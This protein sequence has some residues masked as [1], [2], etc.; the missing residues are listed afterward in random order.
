MSQAK[1]PVWYL[2][3]TQLDCCDEPISL[4]VFYYFFYYDMND[5]DFSADE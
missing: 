5:I 4:P 1:G 3:H 2:P